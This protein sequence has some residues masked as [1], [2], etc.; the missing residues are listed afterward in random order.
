[1]AADSRPY[2]HLIGSV[3]FWKNVQLS[4]IHGFRY[5]KD[6]GI[7]DITEYFEKRHK[8]IWGW[9][10]KDLVDST[11][12]GKVQAVKYKMIREGLANVDGEAATLLNL[13]DFLFDNWDAL[14]TKY[15]WEVKS[16]G[17]K[18]FRN[19]KFLDFLN[20]ERKKTGIGV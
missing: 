16:P 3:V 5:A 19:K 6:F 17:W 2:Y 7:K 18:L 1:M 10:P 12:V 15:N 11:F 8:D 20:A 13:I 4:E 14:K 9:P